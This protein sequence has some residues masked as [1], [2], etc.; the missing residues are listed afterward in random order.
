MKQLLAFLSCTAL[1]LLPNIVQAQ[2]YTPSNRRPAADNSQIGTIV[3]PTGANNFNIT[4]GLQRGQNLLH[5]FSDFSVPTNGSA[6]FTNPQGNQAIITRVTGNNFSDI[7]GLLN[8]NG[9]NFL[10]IN[11]HGVVFGTGV[12]LD[13][14]KAFVTSTASGVDFVDAAGRNYNF[15]VNRAGDVPLLSIDP[16]V[17]FNPARLIMNASIP[18]SRGIENYGILQNKNPG[19]YIGLIGGDVNFYGGQLIAPGAKVELGGLKQSGTVGFSLENGVQFP[20]NVDRGNVSLVTSGTLPSV[21]NVESSGGGSV[22]I[23]ARDIAVEGTGTIIS[24]GIAPRLGSPT[25][26]AGNIKLNATGNIKLSDGA[27]I[28]NRV[29]TGAEGNGGGIEIVASNLAVTKGSFVETRTFGQGDAGQ[30]TIDTNGKLLMD[31]SRIESTIG[32]A[33]VGNSKGIKIDARELEL[34]NAS[35]IRSNTYQS[36]LVNGNGNAGDIDLKIKGNITIL[37]DSFIDTSTY[38]QGDAG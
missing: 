3:N 29:R 1:C 21:I 15:G 7:N 9:A 18:G 36:A 32:S 20:A 13:V 19:Q 12:K 35:R 22:G 25:A 23:F 14:G 4:G 28:R 16:N 27:A 38:G 11:P 33:G 37:K 8:T 2:T 10:L 6:N 31:S 34:T 26:T 17:A 5:S 30:I 24:A